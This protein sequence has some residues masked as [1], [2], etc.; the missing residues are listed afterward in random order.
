MDNTH[1]IAIDQIDLT[2]AVPTVW[3]DSGYATTII[4]SNYFESI[5]KIRN[6]RDRSCTIRYMHK[7]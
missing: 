6:V 4:V 5:V 1:A 7:S 3:R 2:D